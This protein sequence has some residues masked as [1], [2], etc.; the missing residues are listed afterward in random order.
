MAQA[1]DWVAFF[2]FCPEFGNPDGAAGLRACLRLW[3]Q[4]RD[5]LGLPT[6]L[7]N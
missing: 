3:I 4:A 7:P 2:A 6:G 5:T 1:G